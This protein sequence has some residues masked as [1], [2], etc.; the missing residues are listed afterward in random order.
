VIND[1]GSSKSVRQPDFFVRP[2][3]TTESQTNIT[4]SRDSAA[5]EL[6]VPRDCTAS[7]FFA[8]FRGWLKTPWG[9]ASTLVKPV[10][11]NVASN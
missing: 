9:R 1:S 5:D 10:V 11:G 7:D 3:R 4:P 6:I 2:D 8:A